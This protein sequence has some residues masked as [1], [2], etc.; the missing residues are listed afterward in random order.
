M[1]RRQHSLV[2]K[3]HQWLPERR[4]QGSPSMLGVTVALVSYLAAHHPKNHLAGSPVLNK[5]Y[6]PISCLANITWHIPLPFWQ[7]MIYQLICS[8]PQAMYT[9]IASY[10]PSGISSIHLSL[11]ISESWSTASYTSRQTS[12][13]YPDRI[14]QA[15]V[16]GRFRHLHASCKCH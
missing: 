11:M 13:S 1:R 12:K 2:R 8:A 14:F 15:I 7:Q 5:S 4:W 9:V 10:L 6:W 3:A 16:G